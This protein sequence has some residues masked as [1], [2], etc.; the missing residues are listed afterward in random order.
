LPSQIEVSVI[1][2]WWA[3]IEQLYI[4]AKYYFDADTCNANQQYEVAWRM[5]RARSRLGPILQIIQLHKERFLADAQ[6]PIP[7]PCL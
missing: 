2:V 5:V 7:L 6:L 1:K 3:L 4:H